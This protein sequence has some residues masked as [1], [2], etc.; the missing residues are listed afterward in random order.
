MNDARPSHSVDVPAL[1]LDTER[2]LAAERART[3]MRRLFIAASILGAA[4]WVV[5][6]FVSIR[7]SETNGIRASWFAIFPT[8]FGLAGLWSIGGTASPLRALGVAFASGVAGCLLLMFFFLA[9]WPSL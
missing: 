5:T 2:A 1:A 4:L 3:R 8:A 6:F 9:I 7:S